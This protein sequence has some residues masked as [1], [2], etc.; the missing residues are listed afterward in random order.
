MRFLY[1]HCYNFQLIV[2]SSTAYK[3]K[4]FDTDVKF[5]NY[6]FKGEKLFA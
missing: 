4:N 5:I 6:F 3:K 1:D 2:L